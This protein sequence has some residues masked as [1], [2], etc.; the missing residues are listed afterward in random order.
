VQPA[1]NH[2]DNNH[3]LDREKSE[4]MKELNDHV[5]KFFSDIIDLLE[6][7]NG[8]RMQEV[9]GKRDELI[10][11]ANEILVHRIKILKRT[12]K[13]IK[14]SVTYIEMLSETK[15]LLLDVVQLAK[16]DL[17]LFES[18]TSVDGKVEPDLLDLQGDLRASVG[19]N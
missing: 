15:N 12:Q 13:G 2:L 3:A 1:F 16:A 9:A 5:G 6:K 19:K 7:K 8:N 17:K 10:E 11:L 14:F 4:K 18:F